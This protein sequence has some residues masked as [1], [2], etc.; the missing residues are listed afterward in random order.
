MRRTGTRL[1]LVAGVFVAV[2]V[3]LAAFAVA[4]SANA[5]E[6]SDAP[7]SM[8]TAEPGRSAPPLPASDT[9]SPSGDTAAP[10]GT[11]APAPARKIRAIGGQ[12]ILSEGERAI[13]VVTG[14][15]GAPRKIDATGWTAGL[16]VDRRIAGQAEV[17]ST[18]DIAWEELSASRQ[19][20]FDEGERILA[21]LAPLPS[22]S[23]WKKRFPEVGTGKRV[24]IVADRGDAF[25]RSPDATTL[26][27][28]EHYFAMVDDA[29]NG[30]PG[31]RRLAEIA[32]SGDRAVALEALGILEKRKDLAGLLGDDGTPI[33]LQAARAE[34]RDPVIRARALL[35]AARSGLRGVKEAAL[36]LAEPGS[37]I[38]A[39]AYRALGI[40]PHGLTPE[41]AT[42]L[43]TDADPDLRAVGVAL[44]TDPARREQV[45]KLARN[46]EAAKVRVAA[47][48]SLVMRYGASAIP[49]VLPLLEDKEA[50]V[51]GGVARA[52]GQLGEPGVA[53][54]RNVVDKGSEAAALAAVA[55]LTRAGKEGAL[56]L[57]SISHLHTSDKVRAAAKLAMGEGPPKKSHHHGDEH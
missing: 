33:L 11:A 13:A 30:S 16:H 17:G 9:A 19:V 37:P 43:L 55:G 32:A 45:V 54:L 15:I 27:S 3:I 21:V 48:I 34:G 12:N 29:R 41:Q 23:I 44:A 2:V 47:G 7:S 50:V 39:D 6:P 56:A 18:I 53:P 25:L 52:I 14:T 49:E 57:K 51:R 28:L 42:A 38:R 40:L 5:T 26:N 4:G 31:T 1:G 10:A 36:A 20:R 8:P 22:Q 24:L 46:D 35:L